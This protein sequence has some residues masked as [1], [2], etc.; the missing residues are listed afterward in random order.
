MININKL[1][2]IQSYKRFINSVNLS[3][4][5]SIFYPIFVNFLIKVRKRCMNKIKIFFLILINSLFSPLY[6][7]L[8]LFSLFL[9]FIPIFPTKTAKKN[10]KD[11][12]NLSGMQANFFISK[13]F[14]NYFFYLIEAFI[15]APLHLTHWTD[16]TPSDT[17]YTLSEIKKIYSQS[18]NLG[19]VYLLPHMANIEMYTLSVIS[20]L[21]KIKEKDIYALAKPTKFSLF[22]KFLLRYRE[23]EGMKIIWTD[24]N[25]LSNMRQV[26]KKGSSIAML[27]DQKPKTGGA[28]IKF[29]NDYSVFPTSGLRFCMSQN[30][31]VLY[32]SGRRILPGWLAVKTQ[33]GKN[34]HLTANSESHVQGIDTSNL[35]SAPIWQ[36]EQFSERDKPATEEMSYFTKWIEKEIRKT[37][38][39][40]CWDYRKWSRKK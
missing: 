29:F 30:M 22:N 21:K 20:S 12:L 10:L 26:I 18:K 17:A 11:H 9:T 36:F 33:C 15:L 14:L 34:V 3:E 24:K 16:V 23:R 4:E 5:Y 19:F 38:T 6:I 37:P 31:I 32:L 2:L 27:V 25:L 7:F 8:Y 28:F 13:L 1:S 39:Q 35:N 40:W